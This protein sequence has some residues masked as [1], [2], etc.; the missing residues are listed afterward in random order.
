[1]ASPEENDI[2]CK[3]PIRFEGEIFATISYTSLAVGGSLGNMFLILVIYRTP[4][5]RTVCG[6]LISNVAVADLMVTSAVMPIVVFTLVQGL[7]GMCL[8]KTPIEITLVIALLSALS[9]LGCRLLGYHRQRCAHVEKS[10]RK[11]NADQLTTW[12]PRKNQHGCRSAPKKQ[13]NGQDRC[14][15]RTSVLFVLGSYRFCHRLSNSHW[16]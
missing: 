8:F 7:L 1:M 3:I 12:R 11:F 13:A 15:G 10:T 6:I 9:V 4:S 2:Q 14:F 16:P 5:L